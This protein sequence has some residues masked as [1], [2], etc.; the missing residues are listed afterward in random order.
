[1]SCP[2]KHRFAPFSASLRQSE[3]KSLRF[4]LSALVE[5]T[6]AETNDQISALFGT[7]NL[8]ESE[9]RNSPRPPG[10]GLGVRAAPLA[11]RERGRG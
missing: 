8:A 10:E 11:L 3:K 4:L 9:G 6:K 2:T 7:A 5:M 1:M